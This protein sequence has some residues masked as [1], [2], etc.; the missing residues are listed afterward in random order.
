MRDPRGE[1]AERLGD[2]RDVRVLEP[3]PPAV[4]VPPWYADDPVE[5]GEVVPLD[6]PGTT[7]WDEVCRER[8]ELA[9][10]C[11]ER[12]L[13][14]WR[15]LTTMPPGFTE[16]R[17][18]LHR[19]AEHVL[20]PA[21]YAANGKIG[22]RWTPGGFGTPFFADARQVR[23]EGSEIVVDDRREPITTVAAAARLVGVAPGAPAGVYSP[24]TPLAPDEPL[25]VDPAAAGA[26]GDWFG[27]C[28]SVLE[29][30]RDEAGA[31]ASPARVQ[32]WPEHFDLAVDLGPDGA[33]ANYG[34][35]PG[36]DDHPEPYLYVGPWEPR[37]GS[38][39]NA[40]FGAR[41]PFAELVGESDQ[42]ARAL[43]FLREGR[44]RLSA[45]GKP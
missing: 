27:F 42:R 4:A 37:S 25:A 7:S 38:F 3:S 22:L 19:L 13:G 40:P 45:T 24:L 35:S 15:P 5:G 1:A 20:A 21:R 12:W 8:P 43:A 23:V 28:T 11:A 33:R 18:S 29:Q 32:L 31:A 41:L 14:A 2:H 34:G 10:W 26:L 9:G 36:D 39:W 16:T 30:L 44:D 6:R 17:G